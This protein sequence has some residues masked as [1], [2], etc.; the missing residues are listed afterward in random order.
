METLECTSGREVLT[1]V[2]GN[3]LTIVYSV[4]GS[5]TMEGLSRAGHASK[6]DLKTNSDFGYSMVGTGS[7]TPSFRSVSTS[8]W[9]K[10]SLAPRSSNISASNVPVWHYA[11]S[12]PY[13]IGKSG[14]AHFW[15]G[16]GRFAAILGL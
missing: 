12:R 1:V 13:A 15:F 11:Q 5:N 10:R 6:S 7:A 14:L 9:G 3:K 4:P 2:D 16:G 8:T